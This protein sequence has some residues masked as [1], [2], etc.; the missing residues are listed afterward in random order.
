[1]RLFCYLFVCLSYFSIRIRTIELNE[2]L[3]SDKYCKK[4]NNTH[5]IKHPFYLG[6][7]DEENC[8]SVGEDGTRK[9]TKYVGK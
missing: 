7:F 9:E 1:M 8:S 3:M 4:D 2:I 5:H 6:I